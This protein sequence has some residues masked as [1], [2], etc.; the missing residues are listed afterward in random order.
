MYRELV[1]EFEKVAGEVSPEEME[2]ASLEILAELYIP[3][4]NSYTGETTN[5]T[6]LM[7][8]YRN[9]A[10]NAGYAKGIA[11]GAAGLLGLQGAKSIA[12]KQI[13]KYKANKAKTV[14]NK[15]ASEFDEY[16]EKFANTQSY[17]ESLDVL[18]SLSKDMSPE[19]LEVLASEL[20]EKEAIAPFLALGRGLAALRGGLSGAWQGAKSFF[21]SKNVVKAGNKAGFGTV[22]GVAGYARPT[23]QQATAMAA[24]KSVVDTGLL[25]NIRYGGSAGKQQAVNQYN[26]AQQQAA[27]GK[28]NAFTGIPQP[29]SAGAG[30]AGLGAT[31]V[32]MGA[33]MGAPMRTPVTSNKPKAYNK[34][35]TR[36]ETKRDF[37]KQNNANWLESSKQWVQQNPYLATAAGLGA[38]YML[39]NKP[40]PTPMISP[41]MLYHR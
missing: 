18:E 3:A 34:K 39:G 40:Q 24:N 11:I 37:N 4:Y 23:M 20:L 16:L 14:T 32:P 8:H 12:K 30:A 13:A 2:K 27:A 10:G 36:K 17:K 21:K 5:I 26:R 29:T 25:G 35:D 22:P 33:P 15:K 6:D 28:F 9:E 31:G 41:P 19:D 38:G 7:E 1:A